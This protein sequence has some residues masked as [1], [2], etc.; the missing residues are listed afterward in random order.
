MAIVKMDKFTLL[1]FEQEKKN[2]LENLQSFGNVEFSNL[3]DSEWSQEY[4][5]QN[6]S[7]A[8]EISNVEGELSKCRYIIENLSKFEEK[9][10]MLKGLKEG[11]KSYS[12]EELKNIATG[13][14]YQEEYSTLK[15]LENQISINNSDISKFKTGI[16]DLLHWQE[17]DVSVENLRT[18]SHARAILGEIPNENIDSFRA[19]IDSTTQ[20]YY[21][22]VVN[23]E[24][25]YSY[26]LLCIDNYDREAV[27]EVLK[28]QNVKV[29]ELSVDG[30]PSVEMKGFKEKIELK[31]SENNLIEE[32]IRAHS[33]KLDEYKAVYEY[34]SFESH[35]LNSTK[36]FLKSE[37]VVT[38]QGYYPSNLKEE[39]VS[40]LDKTLG[41][42]YYLETEE[43]DGDDTPVK[44]HNNA[45]YEAFEPITEMY[46][47]PMYK[48]IDPTPLFA[49]F[50]IIFFGM[51]L[52]D[53]AYGLLLML[54]TAIALKAFNLDESMKRSMKM[55]FFCGISTSVW[56]LL[57]G[58]FF[59]DMIPIPALWMYPDKN[60]ATLMMASIVMGFIHIYIG[61]GIKGY[62]H[63][64][65]KNYF[66]FVAD[67][68]VWYI[69]LTGAVLWLGGAFMDL[70]SMGIPAVVPVI[71]K[72]ATIV[73]MI[74]IV[75][76]NGGDAKSIGGKIGSGIYALYGITG[77]IGDFVSYTRLAALGLATGFLSLAFN[78]IV[79]MV[80]GSWYTMIFA[81][82]IFI[83]AHIFNMFINAL[84]SYVHACR[85][86]YLEYF[87][88]FYEGGGSAFKPLEYNSKYFKIVK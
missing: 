12:Y 3:T 18:L 64:R 41:E 7:S 86:Q 52:S 50:Y 11:R 21:L 2:L 85:L 45:V 74:G 77:Y 84:G 56:G 42:D 46:S 81:V 79:R 75:F 34:Y 78:I 80:G 32:K 87:G 36:N 61:I 72:W 37:K 26:L 33:D 16:E 17:L 23:S 9:P 48:E 28:N 1:A 22:E 62:M 14:N 88:K 5:L 57:Y 39:F 65:D 71:A 67:V 19:E 66:G 68:L 60:V 82:I 15:D 49:P 69:T 8:E 51:M 53:L 35:R 10:G 63:L 29:C 55:F 47:T 30:V 83:G 13:S 44:L 24:T 31:V 59:G 27:Q 40:L 4:Q 70:G 38:I 76:T 25:K 58:S 54:G 6:D 20:N 73:G 43:A